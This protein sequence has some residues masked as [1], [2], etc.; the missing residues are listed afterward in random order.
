[1]A[2]LKEVDGNIILEL[3]SNFETSF[4]LG[5]FIYMANVTNGSQVRS[6]GLEVAQITTNGAKSFNLTAINPGIKLTDYTYVI[7]LCK[8]ATVTFGYAQLN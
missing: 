4:A 7:I 5:T 1:M 8:P 2:I 3:S 6:S